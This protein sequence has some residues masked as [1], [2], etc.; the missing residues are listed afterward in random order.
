MAKA[1]K[2]QEVVLFDDEERTAKQNVVY[3]SEDMGGW[4]VVNHDGYEM[5]LRYENW[6]KLVELVDQAKK[7]ATK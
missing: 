3:D 5:S 6:L 2:Y 1:E 7:E 4:V